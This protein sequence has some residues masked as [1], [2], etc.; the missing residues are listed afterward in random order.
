MKQ[1]VTRH[2]RLMALRKPERVSQDPM[3][4]KDL[5]R[6]S[7]KIDQVFTRGYDWAAAQERDAVETTGETI[8]KALSITTEELILFFTDVERHHCGVL[9]LGRK[10]HKTRIRWS[11]SLRSIG[12]M[13]QGH[14]DNLAPVDPEVVAE[15]SKQQKSSKLN[16]SPESGIAIPEA[17]R[18]L[19]LT[20]GVPA[21]AIEI[22]I[23]V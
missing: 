19:A 9:V 14:A 20:F 2:Q 4:F 13:A 5:L 1:H 15:A 3:V 22:I 8:I 7:Y 10:G 21:D 11:Y 17:K 23:R 18:R 12:Q 16:T 6:E